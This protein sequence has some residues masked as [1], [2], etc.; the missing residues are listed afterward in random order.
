MTV[1]TTARSAGGR[2][3]WLP[4]PASSRWSGI[5]AAL[6]GW[7][8]AAVRRQR[9]GGLQVRTEGAQVRRGVGAA[10][11]VALLAVA[12]ACG[13]GGNGGQGRGPSGT[14]AGTYTLTVSAS[15]TDPSVTLTHSAT[16]TLTVN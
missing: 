1:T 8:V 13:S 6:I 5:L 3:P 2:R 15:Y 11:A 16:V 12:T 14:P 10:V 4:F 9:L 7:L